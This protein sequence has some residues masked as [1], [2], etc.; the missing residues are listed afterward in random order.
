MSYLVD[1]N[2]LSELRKGRRCDRNVTTWYT[3][4]A[5]SDKF[6]SVLT[7]GEIRRGIERLRGRDLPAAR[8]LDAWLTRLSAQYETRI[9]PVTRDIANQWG[10]WMV[11]DPLPVVDGLLAA[12]AAVHGLTL[13][14]RN[15]KDVSRTGVDCLNP[16][17]GIPPG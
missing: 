1:T 14:T 12:T 13:V 7:L 10:L 5:T 2:V 3:S 16:F 11:P 15:C 4:A 9:L 8:A 6:V 17:A